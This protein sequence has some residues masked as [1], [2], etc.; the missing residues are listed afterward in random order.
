M[1]TVEIL[2]KAR[3]HIA[4]PGMWRQRGRFAEALAGQPCSAFN[5]LGCIT[6]GARKTVYAER[7][8]FA[9]LGHED[10]IGWEDAPSRTQS[11][12]VALFDRA[13]ELAER[14]PTP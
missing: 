13:I 1:T 7:A 12:V 10:V 8:M 9:A 5:A 11:E 3:D 6:R 4:Q 14:E 2:R